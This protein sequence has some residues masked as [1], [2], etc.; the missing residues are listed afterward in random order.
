MSLL[1][2]IRALQMAEGRLKYRDPS[3]G[4]GRIT[5]YLH[6]YVCARVFTQRRERGKM[7]GS[8]GRGVHRCSRSRGEDRI[9]KLVHFNIFYCLGFLS[10]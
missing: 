3:D 4:G 10:F 5:R 6:G 7:V 2:I 9:G 8:G 1:G